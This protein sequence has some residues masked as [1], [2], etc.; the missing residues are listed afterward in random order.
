MTDDDGGG[1]G[2]ILCVCVF[3]QQIDCISALKH[4]VYIQ[5]YIYPCVFFKTCCTGTH[6]FVCQD[7]IGL[8]DKQ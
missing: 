5:M 8:A 7:L 3:L 4:T 1:R 6:L 2:V